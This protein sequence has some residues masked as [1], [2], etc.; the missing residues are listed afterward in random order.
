MDKIF[1]SALEQKRTAGEVCQMQRSIPIQP[2]RGGIILYSVR[3]AK[4]KRYLAGDAAKQMLRKPTRGRNMQKL[5]S[6]KREQMERY[7]QS[8]NEL[9]DHLV[10]LCNNLQ[11]VKNRHMSDFACERIDWDNK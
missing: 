7:V 8:E 2:C 6:N 10:A 1:I 4:V 5:K 11:E 3:I 9:D